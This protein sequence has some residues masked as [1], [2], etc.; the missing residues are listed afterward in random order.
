MSLNQ[1]AKEAHQTARD[2]GFWNNESN[3]LKVVEKLC[4]IHSEVSE[5]LEAWRDD[6]EDVVVAFEFADIIIRVLDLTEFL[7]IDID[8][9]VKKKMKYIIKAVHK[10]ARKEVLT[11]EQVEWLRKAPQGDGV[12]KRLN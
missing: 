7:G 4:L 9:Y 1:L 2:K 10:H 5:V 11:E 3:S 12:S 8:D 6:N